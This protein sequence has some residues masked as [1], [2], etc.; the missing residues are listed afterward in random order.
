MTR[1]RRRERERE[2][3]LYSK[4]LPDRTIWSINQEEGVDGPTFTSSNNFPSKIAKRFGAKFRTTTGNERI[5]NKEVD[6]TSPS[7][8]IIW[9]FDC[10]I[11]GRFFC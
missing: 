9:A 5:E 2:K 8:I 11:Y 3:L 4:H 7:I 6:F 1:R 10:S